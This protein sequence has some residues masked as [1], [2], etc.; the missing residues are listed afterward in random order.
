M[1]LSLPAA[2]LALLACATHAHKSPPCLTPAEATTMATKWA[3]FWS[4]GVVKTIS[5]IS[6]TVTPD[7]V[8]ADYSYGPPSVGIEALFEAVTYIDPFLADVKQFPLLV[9]QTC[10]TIVMRWEETARTTGFNGFV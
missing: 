5:D 10:D 9:I 1:H 3:S 4:Y 2:L 8:N 7:I 6:S